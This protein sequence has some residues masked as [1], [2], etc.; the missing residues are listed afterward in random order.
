MMQEFGLTPSARTRVK[1][2]PKAE[3]DE[4]ESLMGGGRKKA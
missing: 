3:E 1:G 4:F 2:D